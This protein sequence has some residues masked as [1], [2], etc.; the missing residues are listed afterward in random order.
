MVQSISACTWF[1]Q[2][3]ASLAFS[4]VY[5]GLLSLILPLT[6]ASTKLLR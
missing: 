5:H 1:A 3:I 2:V 6:L 4:R